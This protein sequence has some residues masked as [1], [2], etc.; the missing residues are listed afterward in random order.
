M[1]TKISL[2]ATPGSCLADMTTR[3][4]IIVTERL[5]AIEQRLGRIE[6]RLVPQGP[7]SRDREQ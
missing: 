5:T 1:I 3:K 7:S 2:V 6:N 4:Y